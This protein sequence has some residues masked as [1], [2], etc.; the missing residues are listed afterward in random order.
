MNGVKYQ[1][2]RA[3]STTATDSSMIVKGNNDRL[4]APKVDRTYLANIDGEDK[5]RPRLGQ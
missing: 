3:H 2:F 4:D 5:N 1:S